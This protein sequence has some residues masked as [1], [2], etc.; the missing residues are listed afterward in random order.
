LSAAWSEPYIGGSLRKA[1]LKGTAFFALQRRAGRK[2]PFGPAVS[3]LCSSARRIAVQQNLQLRLAALRSRAWAALS[4][5]T[6]GPETVVHR[7]ARIE[8]RDGSVQI[9]RHCAIHELACLYGDS[10]AIVLGDRV[11]IHPFAVL[12]GDGNVTIGSDVQIS[13]HVVIVSD[14]LHYRDA[15]RLIAE[16]GRD[17]DGIVIEDDVWIGAHATILDGVIVAR[18]SVI[19]AG[20]VVTKSTEA[21]GVYAGVPAR[22]I[23]G[24][25]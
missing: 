21:Y 20:A 5:Y 19:A 14:N 25:Q 22:R 12:Y 8:P 18:G 9:G 23:G 17:R 7:L 3:V 10:G 6:I 24:R 16:Q 4:G 15:G 13:T 2:A 11:T 1:V